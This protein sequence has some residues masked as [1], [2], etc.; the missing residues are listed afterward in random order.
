MASVLVDPMRR[1]LAISLFSLTSLAFA[2]DYKVAVASTAPAGLP[3]SVASLLNKEGTQVSG[4][5]GKVAFEI[6]MRATAPTGPTTKEENVS[7]PTIPHGALV[8]VISF[9]KNWSDR[10]GQTIK[11]G[12]YTMRYSM[13][14]ING[15]HQGVAPQRDFFL[16]TPVAADT[17]GSA[18]P[19]F[20]DL[21]TMSRKASGTP[22]PAVFSVY[23]TDGNHTG[24]AKEGEHDWV[25][26]T[27][28]GATPVSIILVGKAEG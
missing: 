14:P 17:N 18:L 2:D 16:L 12:A 11:A 19:N 26:H 5:D 4:P 27:K 1:F 22:H 6:W 21:M 15:D 3:D 28:I 25:L 23:K 9:P 7:L 10:R 20:D 24:F 13:F 8:A